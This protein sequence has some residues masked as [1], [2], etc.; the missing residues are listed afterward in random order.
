MGLIKN[1]GGVG[2]FQ[3]SEKERLFHLLYQPNCN[4]AIS[5]LFLQPSKKGL[6]L[7]FSLGMQEENISGNSIEGRVYWFIVKIVGVLPVPTDRTGIGWWALFYVGIIDSLEDKSMRLVQFKK[8]FP[9]TLLGHTFERRAYWLLFC[10]ESYQGISY[11]HVH[12][13]TK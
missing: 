13:K 4:L 2:L 12:T 5:S 3:I 1:K 10:F 6:S 7:R 11:S 8:A 9:L